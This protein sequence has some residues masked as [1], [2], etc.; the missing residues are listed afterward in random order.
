MDPRIVKFTGWGHNPYGE[1]SI[2][3]GLSYVVAVAAGADHSLALK[4]DGTVIAW[5]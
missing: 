5:G 1:S 4:A 2:P 3:N